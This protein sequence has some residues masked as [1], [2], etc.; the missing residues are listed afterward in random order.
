M[1][2]LASLGLA[3][4]LAG[5]SANQLAADIGVVSSDIN[6]ITAALQTPAAQQAIA[7]L[8]AAYKGTVCGL[9]VGSKFA[10]QIAVDLRATKTV[11]AAQIVVATSST[12]CTSA[13]GVVA[14]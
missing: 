8:K 6:T 4:A 5:C 2:R 11:N 12:A 1:K 14:S 3:C 9:V 10:S 7:T 13:G